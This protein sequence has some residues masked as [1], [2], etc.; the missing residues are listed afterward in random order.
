MTD[1]PSPLRESYQVAIGQVMQLAAEHRKVQRRHDRTAPYSPQND[2]D[3][4][5]LSAQLT[6]IN[7]DHIRSV[8]ELEG[9]ISALKESYEKARQELNVL[10][11]QHEKLSSLIRQAETFFELSDKAELSALEQVQLTVSRQSIM[12]NGITSRIE[13]EHLKSSLSDTDKRITALKENFKRCQQLYDVYSDI[14][15]TYREISQGDY[16]SK[17]VAEEQKKRENRKNTETL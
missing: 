13:L 7:R 10:T 15:A 6:I 8:G 12:N 11:V 5:R 4:Y 3:V 16:I 2:L 14:A 17:L 9:K 1:E